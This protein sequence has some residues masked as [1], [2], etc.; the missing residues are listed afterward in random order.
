MDGQRVLKL[1][2][3]SNSKGQM[4]LQNDVLIFNSWEWWP[5]PKKYEPW[6]FVSYGTRFHAEIDRPTAFERAMETWARWVNANVDPNKVKVFFQ[7]ISPAHTNAS[8]WG[9]RM[10]MDC[11]GQTNPLKP[12]YPGGQNPIEVI[13]KRVLANI[14]DHKVNLLQITSLSQLRVDGH[15]SIYGSRSGI[16]GCG[17]W[18]LPGVPDVWNQF[19]YASLF[20]N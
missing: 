9:G 3:L 11:K 4:W 2:Q 7:D 5:R 10:G 15:P 18:C 16:I 20:A 8:E 13:L 17:H 14:T 12:P 1:D 6:D 19:L